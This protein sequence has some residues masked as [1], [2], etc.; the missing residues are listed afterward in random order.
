MLRATSI[1]YL[2]FIFISKA[3]KKKKLQN[4]GDTSNEF[5]LVRLKW[6]KSFNDKIF[7]FKQQK[8]KS[9]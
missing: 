4:N 6:F 7:I 3:K 5:P 9:F 2:I 8:K 1:D